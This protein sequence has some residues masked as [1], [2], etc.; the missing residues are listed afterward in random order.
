MEMKRALLWYL[1]VLV[2]LAA[3]LYLFLELF[4]NKQESAAIPASGEEAVSSVDAGKTPLVTDAAAQ[5]ASSGE[6]TSEDISPVQAGGSAASGDVVAPSTAQSSR[7]TPAAPA[8]TGSAA[9]NYTVQVAALASREKASGVVDKLRNDG[10][11]GGRI[12]ENMGDE[13][14][15]VWIGSFA[16]KAEALEMAERLKGKGYNTYVRRE[17]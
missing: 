9:G 4:V 6:I 2:A 17:Q 8:V 5:A 1:V 15:R 11:P 3:G 16:T 12:A 13:F 7:T 10:F 14:N